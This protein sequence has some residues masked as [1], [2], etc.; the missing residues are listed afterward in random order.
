MTK[1]LTIF[2]LLS[3]ALT[4]CT[5]QQIGNKNGNWT[6]GAEPNNEYEYNIAVS[7]SDKIYTVGGDNSGAFEVYDTM[8]SKWNSLA[9]LPRSR[10]FIGGTIL[11]NEIYV[12]GG[13]DS[14]RKYSAAVEKYNITENKWSVCKNLNSPRSRLAV[15]S[16]AGKIYAIG[17][18]EGTDDKN[19]KNSSAIEEYD[20]KINVWTQKTDMPTP[21]HGHSAIVI[22]SKILVVGGYVDTETAMEPSAIVEQYDPITN[23]WSKKSE[24]PTPRGFLGLVL[25]DNYVYAIAGRVRQDKGPIEQYDYKK[26]LW[27]KLEPM[28][29]WRNRFGITAIGNKVYIIGGENNPKSFLISEIKDK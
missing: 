8:T 24:M 27:T 14:S 11:A 7:V 26:N 2:I 10:T 6:K 5:S 21:R 18:L 25:I 28:P 22:D 9:K 1:K 15:V 4:I 29:V 23:K 19:C 17:G 13:I 20:P 16:Y 12:I 3:S